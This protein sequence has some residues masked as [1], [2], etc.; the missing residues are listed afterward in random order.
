MANNLPSAG[1]RRTENLSGRSLSMSLMSALEVVIRPADTS[2]VRVMAVADTQEELDC[3]E[4]S[5]GETARIR[6]KSRNGG[7]GGGF[8]IQSINGATV[9]RSSGNVFI[10]GNGGSISINSGSVE[11]CTLRLAIQVPRGFDVALDASGAL[12]VSMGEIG[13]LEL[14]ASGQ[15]Q[16]SCAKVAG[17]LSVEVSGQCRVDIAELAADKARLEASGQCAVSVERGRVH[18]LKVDVSGMVQMG[19]ALTAQK[20]SL[21]AS[22]MSAIT[23]DSVTGELDEDRSGMARIQVKQRGIAPESSMPARRF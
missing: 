16:V 8:A 11:E 20:A 15:C 6:Q 7:D 9:I 18:K 2:E 23:V 22:G 4:L 10:S 21:E 5:S 1:L 17:D 14:D 13:A 19:L 12:K 3:L